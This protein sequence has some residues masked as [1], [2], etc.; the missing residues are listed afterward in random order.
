[1]TVTTDERLDVLF[2]EIEQVNQKLAL[3]VSGAKEAYSTAEFARLVEKAEFTV[4]Q[5]CR[6]GRVNASKSGSG[7]G[8]ESAWVI[9]H[10]EYLRYQREGLLVLRRNGKNGNSYYH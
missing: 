7:C 3:I 8:P 1:M 2:K 5:W 9:R 4:R 6:L 10:D